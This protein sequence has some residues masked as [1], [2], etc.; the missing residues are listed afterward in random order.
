MLKNDGNQE[1]RTNGPEKIGK[2][3]Y[4]TP[5]IETLYSG[6]RFRSRLEA[7]WAAFFDQMGW[8]WLYEPIELGGWLPDF[9][10][11]DIGTL[12]EVKPF[13]SYAE[14]EQEVIPKV[15]LAMATATERD[16]L[17]CGTDPR[18]L[19]ISDRVSQLDDEP[20]WSVTFDQVSIG[21]IQASSGPE[22]IA[23]TAESGSWRDRITGFYDGRRSWPGDLSRFDNAKRVADAWKIATNLT[24]W[25]K[26]DDTR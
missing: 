24:K 11:G 8:Q 10:I 19:W 26:Y 13:A 9:E 3:I 18:F 17:L 1:R 7:R 2:F 6:I 16:V 25:S 15:V 5:A 23:L 21:N 12:V 14:F 20:G 4:R 22:M